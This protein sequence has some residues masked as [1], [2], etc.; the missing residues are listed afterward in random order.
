MVDLAGW[1]DWTDGR[2]GERTD[3][4]TDRLKDRRIEG[5][6]TVVF[7]FVW[8]GVDEWMGGWIDGSTDGR[9]DGLGEQTSKRRAGGWASGRTDR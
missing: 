9:M 6:T 8:L 1:L 2:L 4:R 3:G 5:G 7:D